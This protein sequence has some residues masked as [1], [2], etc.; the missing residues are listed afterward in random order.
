MRS[1][2]LIAPRFVRLLA[3]VLG[4][5]LLFRRGQTEWAGAGGRAAAWRAVVAGVAIGHAARSRAA[6][7]A[8]AS[9]SPGADFHRAGA[10][11]GCEL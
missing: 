6:A 1:R 3:V 9:R 4:C 2:L 7:R 5:G 8:A 11:L 10:G